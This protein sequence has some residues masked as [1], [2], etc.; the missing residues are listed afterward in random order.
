MP[1]RHRAGNASAAI[2]LAARIELVTADLTRIRADAIVNAANSS[3]LGGGGVDGAIH[4]AAGPKLLAECREIGGCP[5]GEARLTGGYALPARYV[6]HTVV[7]VWRGGGMRESQLLAACYSEAL[8]LA[9][10]SEIA[11]IAFPALG[12]GAYGYPFEL[13]SEIAIRTVAAW[14]VAHEWPRRVTFCCLHEP[15]T[16]LYRGTLARF[17]ISL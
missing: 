4:H 1:T 12:T 11:G 10:R 5:P 14:L 3:L 8:R 7:P 2:G 16:A 13:A 9:K 6:I 15:E 17:G